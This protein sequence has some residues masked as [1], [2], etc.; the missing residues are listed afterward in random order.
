M[1]MASTRKTEI[2]ESGRVNRF[3]GEMRDLLP[4]RFRDLNPSHVRCPDGIGA[5]MGR[6]LSNG[7]NLLSCVASF[8]VDCFVGVPAR[9]GE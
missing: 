3:L 5:D 7:G 6:S 8:A 4:G 1:L 2:V 9:D